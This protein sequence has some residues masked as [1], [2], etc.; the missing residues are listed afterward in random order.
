MIR[1][2]ERIITAMLLAT[3]QEVKITMIF[4]TITT[5]SKMHIVLNVREWFIHEKMTLFMWHT[6]D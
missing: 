1:L 2:F 6:F 5:K 3:S 4:K